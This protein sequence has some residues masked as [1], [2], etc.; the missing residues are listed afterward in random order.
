MLQEIVG[1]K[2]QIAQLTAQVDVG[3]IP[4]AYL[5]C[6][7]EGVGKKMVALHFA[8]LLLCEAAKDRPCNKCSAC[9]KVDSLSHPDLFFVAPEKFIITI[10]QIRE[11][12]QDISLHAMEG[13]YKVVIIDEAHGMN[14]AAAN[15][16]LKTLEEPPPA[17]HLIL[18][19]SRENMLLPTIISRCQRVQFQALCNDEVKNYLVGTKKMQK[20]SAETMSRISCGSIG[21][22]LSMDSAVVQ[23][24]VS[25]IIK[26]FTSISPEFIIDTSKAWGDDTPNIPL[27]LHLIALWC[28]DLLLAKIGLGPKNLYFSNF[29]RDIE[30]I[31]RSR[32][33]NKL[34]GSLGGIL[35][36][37]ADAEGTYNKQLMF[38]QLLF[39]LP[40]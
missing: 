29:S 22:A 14:R 13:R 25:V 24:V 19:T 36:L 1:H 20:D 18:V 27:R 39:K 11:L 3:R 15:S 38:E 35:A 8:R 34:E 6:G 32:S 37:Q 33:S 12:Q 26:V 40:A 17:T 31:A 10:D 5:F 9:H 28:R 2:T 16:L 7:P 30:N 23:D 21:T 4:S